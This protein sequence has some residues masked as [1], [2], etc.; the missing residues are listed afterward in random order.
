MRKKA[1]PNFLLGVCQEIIEYLEEELGLEVFKDNDKMKCKPKRR[2]Y[3]DNET[4]DKIIWHLYSVHNYS[5][6]EIAQQLSKIN[7]D[8][9]YM[10]Y[11]SIRKVI[12]REKKLLK[13]A[14]KLKESSMATV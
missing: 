4:R 7:P 2:K 5:Y 9:S 13:E 14:E 8:W 12:F 3:L 1:N 6:K 11:D 10:N